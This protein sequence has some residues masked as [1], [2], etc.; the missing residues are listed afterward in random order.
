MGEASL[1]PEDLSGMLCCTWEQ[2]E[3]LEKVHSTCLEVSVNLALGLS[4]T[5]YII[6]S[7]N[8]SMHQQS[9]DS[10]LSNT[11]K[12][13][14]HL[15]Q[16]EELMERDMKERDE[17]TVCYCCFSWCNQHDVDCICTYNYVCNSLW[18]LLCIVQITIVVI[19]G[20]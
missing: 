11:K 12:P 17:I 6:Y 19:M 20:Y 2:I 10:H 14:F 8:R 5:N 4:W 9:K 7:S 13:I 18:R 16:I 1:Y 15:C 3:S